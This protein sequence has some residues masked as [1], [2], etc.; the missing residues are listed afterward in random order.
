MS[1]TIQ[2]K[3]GGFKERNIDPVSSGRSLMWT[4]VMILGDLIQVFEKIKNLKNGHGDP[5]KRSKR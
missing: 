5:Q 4:T 3:W 2:K 1:K